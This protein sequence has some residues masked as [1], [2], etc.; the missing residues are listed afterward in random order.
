[1]YEL[2]KSIS[3]VVY[4]SSVRLIKTL[5]G[6]RSLWTMRRSWR[7]FRLCA[8]VFIKTSSTRKPSALMSAVLRVAASTSPVTL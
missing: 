5:L 8:T 6:L 3:F 1:M 7:S 4:P 2:S